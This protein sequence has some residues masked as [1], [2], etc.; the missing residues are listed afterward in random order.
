[1]FVLFVAGAYAATGYR[2]QHKA[3]LTYVMRT[4]TVT[5]DDVHKLAAGYYT[6]T[7][8][9]RCPS[10]ERVLGGGFFHSRGLYE[11]RGASVAGYTSVWYSGSVADGTA[12]SVSADVYTN[13]GRYELQA[14]ATCAKPS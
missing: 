11:P 6:L 2:S 14:F 13:G 7:S 5:S 10:G 4:H 12:W 8:T 1:M 3:P 9:A